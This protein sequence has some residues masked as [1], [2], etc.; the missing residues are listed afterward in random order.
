VSTFSTNALPR[1]H[2]TSH[3][4]LLLAAEWRAKSGVPPRFSRFL[5]A[6][7]PPAAIFVDPDDDSAGPTKRRKPAQPPGSSGGGI[8]AGAAA[9]IAARPAASPKVAPP[10]KKAPGLRDVLKKFGKVRR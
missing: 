2:L 3:V 8:A 7:I 1:C 9:P 6:A 10:P 4:A 5:P